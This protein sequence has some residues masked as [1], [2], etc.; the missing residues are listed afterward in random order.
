MF[1]EVIVL[2]QLKMEINIPSLVYKYVTSM[3]YFMA[4]G[5]ISGH[6]QR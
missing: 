5:S 6:M 4:G 3:K 2:H 1:A